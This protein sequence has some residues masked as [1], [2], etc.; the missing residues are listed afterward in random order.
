MPSTKSKKKQWPLKVRFET[1]LHHGNGLGMAGLVDR[2][3]LRDS[4]GMPYLAGSALKGKFRWAVLSLKLARD[5]SACEFGDRPDCCEDDPCDVCHLFGSRV[6]RG[7]TTFR[8]GYPDEQYA[9]LLGSG[10]TPT[11]ALFRR[12]ATY[13]ATTAMNRVTG[14]AREGMLFS[15]EILPAGMEFRSE[16][17]GPEEFEGLLGDAARLLTHFGAGGARGLGRCDFLF[18]ERAR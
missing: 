16:I 13:R 12:D 17:R 8:D 1:A 7:A 3:A 10:G 4:D 6:L 14:I 15:T 18:G 11:R 5:E 2:C 9:H